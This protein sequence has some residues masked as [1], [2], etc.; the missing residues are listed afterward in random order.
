[1]NTD[2][3]A[4]YALIGPAG[5]AL[6]IT[7]L[8]GIFLILRT[9]IFLTV[10]W[11]EFRKTFPEMERSEPAGQCM[12]YEGDNPLICII[13]DIVQTHAE[14]SEDIRAEVAYL[15]H[16]N[17]EKVTRDLCWIRLI[18]VMSPMLGLLGTIFGMVSVFEAIGK[19]GGAPDAGMLATGIGEA[20]MTTIMGLCVAIPALM[21]YYYLTLRFKGFHIEVVEY[22]YRALEFCGRRRRG[23]MYAEDCNA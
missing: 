18:S 21:A 15:F 1:M 8:A 14:H 13:R 7:A 5:C 20:L 23:N 9:C 17:F 3:M 2:F 19:N 11:R 4:I 12:A 16:R 10:I 6:A 22:S